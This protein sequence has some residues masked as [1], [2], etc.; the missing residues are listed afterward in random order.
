MQ[1]KTE[2]SDMNQEPLEYS[3]YLVI[4]VTNLNY[5]TQTSTDKTIPSL[6]ECIIVENAAQS[7]DRRLLNR[8]VK[9]K[10][11]YDYYYTSFTTSEVIKWN[12]VLLCS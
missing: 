1:F 7:A 8:A 3:I 5:N 12:T 11:E 10:R 2:S 6:C 4:W 9:S